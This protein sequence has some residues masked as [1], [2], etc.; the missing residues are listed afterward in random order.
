MKQKVVFQDISCKMKNYWSLSTNYA[1]QVNPSAISYHSCVTE[2]KISQRVIPAAV[3]VSFLHETQGTKDRCAVRSRNTAHLRYV[4]PYSPV[5][6]TSWKQL[7]SYQALGVA[8]FSVFKSK[9]RPGLSSTLASLVIGP[10]DLTK[11]TVSTKKVFLIPIYI[12]ILTLVILTKALEYKTVNW[13]AIHRIDRYGPWWC[14]ERSW[15]YTV[16]LYFNKCL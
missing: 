16:I 9:P 5:I 11:V 3:K 8:G 12:Y 1:R 15:A 2:F 7:F 4:N 6:S 13:L 10:T 14:E